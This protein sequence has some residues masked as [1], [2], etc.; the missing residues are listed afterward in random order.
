MRRFARLDG[1]GAPSLHELILTTKIP[2]LAKC[3]LGWGTLLG[4][5]LSVAG[6]TPAL[7]S[8]IR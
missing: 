7:L 4:L 2:T 3:A 1:R 5:F 8:C 6:G